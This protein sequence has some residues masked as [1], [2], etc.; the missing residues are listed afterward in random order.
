MRGEDGTHWYRWLILGVILA[1][2]LTG[3]REAQ[4]DHITKTQDMV[5]DRMEDVQLELVQE[6]EA[7]EEEQEIPGSDYIQSE[8][9]W[10]EQ[11]P[12][13]EYKG[14]I[15]LSEENMRDVIT[16]FMNIDSEEELPQLA[17]L[18]LTENFYYKCLDKFPYLINHDKADK[19]KVMFWGMTE[20]NKCVSY[21]VFYYGE[22]WEDQE[23][24]SYY[25]TMDIKDRQIDDMEII[26]VQHRE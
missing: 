8:D 6:T 1:G 4:A 10:L 19:F 2:G 23:L 11:Q 3:C 22:I 13:E 12:E 16:A 25:L 20:E 17:E 5:S 18:P 24:E 9:E 26:S 15:Y 21:C 14:G 7:V